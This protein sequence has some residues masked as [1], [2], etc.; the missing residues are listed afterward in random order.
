MGN[1]PVD[2]I[3]F[4]FAFDMSEAKAA[5]AAIPPA[6]DDPN[7]LRR[8]WP[9]TKDETRDALNDKDWVRAIMGTDTTL[10]YHLLK[11]AQWTLAEMSLWNSAASVGL[12]ETHYKLATDYS[13]YDPTPMGELIRLM[14]RM[15]GAKPK[16]TPPDAPPASN[17]PSASDD[18]G[19]K[20]VA[21]DKKAADWAGVFAEW[22]GVQEDEP[23]LATRLPAWKRL[24]DTMT[25]EGKAAPPKVSLVGVDL[26]IEW[27]KF[28]VETKNEVKWCVGAMWET[29]V[30]EPNPPKANGMC[31][32]VHREKKV[33]QFFWKN[34]SYGKLTSNQYASVGLLERF[35]A[36]SAPLL[37]TLDG[38]GPPLKIQ[39]D[40]YSKSHGDKIASFTLGPSPFPL[41]SIK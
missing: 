19:D 8:E 31:D 4:V 25:I 7:R 40:A 21:G 38:P 2:R 15:D 33:E 39:M 34:V 12:D 28:A 14:K 18:K 10:L 29:W 23:D 5:R 11:K 35:T 41:L 9:Q 32:L 16:P 36:D 24:R 6:A 27:P 22:Y 1:Q 17:G 30:N 13:D 3:F 26:K 37:I 20:K